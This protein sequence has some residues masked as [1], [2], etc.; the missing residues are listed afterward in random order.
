MLTKYDMVVNMAEALS[1]EHSH[2]KPDDK[3]SPGAPRPFDSKMDNSRL[4]SLGISHHS[5]FKETI[6]EVLLPWLS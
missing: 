2:I 3:P 6:K 5:N 1:L 4:I